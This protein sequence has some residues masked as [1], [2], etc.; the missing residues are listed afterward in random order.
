MTPTDPIRDEA[1]K[2]LAEALQTYSGAVPLVAVA[3]ADGILDTSPT[4]ARRLAFGTT[5]DAAVAALPRGWEGPFLGPDGASW[6]A[7]AY[8]PAPFGVEADGAHFDADTPE[9]ALA[10]LAAKLGSGR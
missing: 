2:V 7:A 8:E 9:L 5:W 6:T 4:L 3:M 1:V 10:A